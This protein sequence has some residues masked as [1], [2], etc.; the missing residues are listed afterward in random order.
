MSS[1]NPRSKQAG[2]SCSLLSDQVSIL[3]HPPSHGHLLAVGDARGIL[4][5]PQHLSKPDCPSHLPDRGR[6]G[7][8]ALN[9]VDRAGVAGS[10]SWRVGA[11]S[12]GSHPSPQVSLLFPLPHISPCCAPPR[13]T[14]STFDTPDWPPTLLS[15][16][17]VVPPPERALSTYVLRLRA[18]FGSGR[19]WPGLD[20]AR[21]WSP[22]A[23]G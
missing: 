7:D 4:S 22:S 12:P 2:C 21:R 5:P 10:P 3:P 20:A 18:D 17:G 23:R 6:A 11:N 16:C 15:P 9:F 1:R 14:L 13:W 19:T 8:E